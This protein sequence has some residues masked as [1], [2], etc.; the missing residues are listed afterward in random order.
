MSSFTVASGTTVTS[1]KTVGGDDTGVIAAGG[2]L[3]AATDIVWT[4]GSTRPGVVIDN[5]GT[6]SAT[7]AR[8]RHRRARSRPAASA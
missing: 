8:H 7:N 2:T 4:G 5:A 6:I 1:A 3:Q